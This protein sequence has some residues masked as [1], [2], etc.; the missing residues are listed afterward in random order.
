MTGRPDDTPA[1][2][3]GDRKVAAGEEAPPVQEPSGTE[4]HE[5]LT[6][7]VEALFDGPPPEITA[8]RL[9]EAEWTTPTL[10]R[11]PRRR[12]IPMLAAG[13][14]FVALAGGV[15]AALSSSAQGHRTGA[16]QGPIVPQRNQLVPYG[17]AV[18]GSCL[19]VDRQVT[20]ELR[21]WGVYT[22]DP[23][24][25]NGTPPAGRQLAPH[26]FADFTI[27][28]GLDAFASISTRPADP[29]GWQVGSGARQLPSGPG[30]SCAGSI[31]ADAPDASVAGSA[32]ILRRPGPFIYWTLDNT[33]QWKRV[34]DDRAEP[35]P[36]PCA[37]DP[38]RAPAYRGSPPAAGAGWH[39]AIE[40]FCTRVA[41]HQFYVAGTPGRCPGGGDMS[42]WPRSNYINQYAAGTRLGLPV[43][44]GV[45][46]GNA[47]G[48]ASLLMAM[49]ASEQSVQRD[50]KT[51]ASAVARLPTLEQCSTP[52]CTARA[53][54]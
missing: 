12:L 34:P 26:D 14:A 4:V 19:A 29:A 30:D 49:F 33:V 41:W 31:R 22:I 17:S 52:R 21:G 5:A 15:S 7:E 42:N 45:A 3:G 2:V 40:R 8:E 20:N 10:A 47:C 50:P 38:A 54:I 48:P 6:A 25:P 27:P 35:A 46:G 13:A 37:G 16:K 9:G 43:G 44:R 23:G 39:W 32:V 18:T 24:R 28:P 11:A 53:V 1:G 51:L 36:Q